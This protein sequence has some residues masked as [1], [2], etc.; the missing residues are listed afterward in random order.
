M[1]MTDAGT[2]VPMSISI[3]VDLNMSIPISH[4]RV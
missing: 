4:F 3:N 2:S 1:L